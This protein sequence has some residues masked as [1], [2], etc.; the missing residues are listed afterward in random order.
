M[1]GD[2]PKTGV[3]CVTQAAE[4][5][6]SADLF[7]E[8]QGEIE[9]ARLAGGAFAPPAK[10]AAGRP[11][12]SGDRKTLKVFALLRAQGYRDPME[13]LAALASMD[14]VTLGDRLC[15]GLGD[16]KPA[17][18]LRAR[19]TA[20]KLVA[21]AAGDLMPFAY[22]RLPQEVEVRSEGEHRTLFVI[23][24]ASEQYQTLSGVARDVS[25]DGASDDED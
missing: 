23:A 3:S 21:K 16:L 1:S 15:K 10:R 18:R 11:K 24:D 19:E 8:V 14:P 13:Q 6:D 22:R 17:D 9:T 2:E 5:E 20:A 7:G 12:G 4:G 25:D